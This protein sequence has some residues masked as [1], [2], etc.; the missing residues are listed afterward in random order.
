MITRFFDWLDRFLKYAVVALV[1]FMLVALTAQIVMRYVVSMPLSWSEELALLAFGWVTLLTTALAVRS[2]THV[3]MAALDAILPP[4]PR[5]ALA[6]AIS[7]A[8]AALGIYI[9]LGGWEYVAMSIGMTSAA[10]AYPISWQN[11]GAPVCGI[12]LCLFSLEQIYLQLF[13]K[14]SS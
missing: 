14:I 11:L 10:V 8:V 12:L 7:L 2:A 1:L 3:R 4:T 5:K 13:K 9:A 6:V